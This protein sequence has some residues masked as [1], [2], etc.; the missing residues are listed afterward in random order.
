[1]KTLFLSDLDGTLLRSDAK[2]SPFTNQVINELTEQGLLFSYATARSYLT[3]CKATA[4]L[5]ARI[6]LITYNGTLVRDNVS[7]KLLFSQFFSFKEAKELL[8][9]LLENEIFPIVYAYDGQ[10]HFSYLPEEINKRTEAFLS[11]RRPDVRD[12][13]VLKKEQLLEGEVFYFTCIDEKEK[14][15]PLFER[16]RK[17]FHCFLQP[18]IYS[19]DFLFEVIPQEASKAQAALQL[20]E[21]L[22][23]QRLVA[24]GDGENDLDLFQAADEAYAVS[25]ASEKLKTAATAVIGSNNEDAMAHWLLEHFTTD[26]ETTESEVRLCMTPEK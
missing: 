15:E 5:T 7:G 10:E 22:G 17:Q 19:G 21:R 2:T 4:G 18:E 11:K 12:R 6:P 26:L 13:P 24:F 25:N 9:V 23:A 8:A 1:M 16:Y 3:A 20:K 14:L